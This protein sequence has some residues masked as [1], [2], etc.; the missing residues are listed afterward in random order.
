MDRK[1]KP[2]VLDL[3][4]G[5]YDSRKTCVTHGV[6]RTELNPPNKKFKSL[7][8]RD[9]TVTYPYSVSKDEQKKTIQYLKDHSEV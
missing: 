6:G 5:G 8:M 3:K 1:A 2:L 9:S 7:N 4:S